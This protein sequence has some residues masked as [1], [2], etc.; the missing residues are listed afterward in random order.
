MDLIVSEG[1]KV[2]A[3]LAPKDKNGNPAKIDGVP[4]WEEDSDLGNINMI[5]AEDG[6]SATFEIGNFDED[7]TVT[8][9]VTADIDLGDDI[10]EFEEVHTLT[11][12]ADKATD[13]GFSWVLVEDEKPEDTAPGAAA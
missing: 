5:V 11:V 10:E 8:V 7:E 4:V 13:L 3:T 6:M 2:R 1:M 9:T 12:V